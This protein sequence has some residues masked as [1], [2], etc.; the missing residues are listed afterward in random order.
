MNRV[1][2][3]G[4]GA[5]TSIGIGKDQFWDALLAGSSGISAVSSFDTSSF[6]TRVGGE[7]KNF[8]AE[9]L[10]NSK[11]FIRY[12]RASQLA[13]AASILAINDGK[14]NSKF[15]NIDVLV[16]TT[17]GES[18]ILESIDHIWA[19]KGDSEVPAEMI[20]KYPGNNLALSI[21]LEVGSRGLAMVI[22]TAC[23]AGNYAIGYAYDLIKSGRSSAVLAGGSDA[24]SKVAFTGFS[25]MFAMAKD[26]CRPFDKN[27]EGMLVGEGAGFILIEEEK[28]ALKRKANIYAEIC[29]YGL[30]CDAS[31]MTIP[32]QSGVAEV[33]KKALSSSRMTINDVDYISAHGTGTP[34]NDKTECGAIRQIF[35]N[36]NVAVSSIKSMLGHTM[37]AASALEAI[38]C[39]LAIHRSKIPP[40]INYETPDQDCLV[41]CVPN[42]Y[43]S[44]EVN[45]ALNNSFAFGGNNACVVFKKFK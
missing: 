33:M 12:G 18:Q 7:I 27:R 20:S 30:S 21:A 14:K 45:V 31:H 5:V 41:D 3:T 29:G 43:K 2:V 38:A 25:R 24:F 44:K 15:E 23:A 37:G 34:A 19:S 40:T 10:K 11:N 1:V 22:P 13:V 6:P 17:M 9:Q 42:V 8:K 35:G 32:N 26:K 4:M 28:E 16:G 39:V 36:H